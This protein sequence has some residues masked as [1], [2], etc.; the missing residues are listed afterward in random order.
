MTSPDSEGVEAEDKPKSHY[1]LDCSRQW[2]GDDPDCD[3]ERCPFTALTPSRG[4][5]GGEI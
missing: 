3:D 5:G 1:C 2:F 4:E